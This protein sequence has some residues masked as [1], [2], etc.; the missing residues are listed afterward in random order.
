M[1]GPALLDA[2]VLF[3]QM[4]RDVM[5]SLAAAQAFEARWTHPIHDEWTR[6]VLKERPDIAPVILQKVRVLMDA[7]VPNCLVEGFEPL[8]AT[9]QLPDPNDRHVVVADEPEKGACRPR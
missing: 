8:I 3:P 2:N 7:N 9:L 4:L 5:V 1:I 6:N